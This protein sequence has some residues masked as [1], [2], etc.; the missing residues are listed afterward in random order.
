MYLISCIILF[1]SVLPETPPPYSLQH[2][3]NIVPKTT[4]REGGI[5]ASDP[6]AEIRQ[7]LE[8]LKKQDIHGKHF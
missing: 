4:L 2:S 8:K 1:A 5:N 6:D 7:R 3:A